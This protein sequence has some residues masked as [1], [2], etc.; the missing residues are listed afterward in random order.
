MTDKSL[1]TRIAPNDEKALLMRRLEIPA[2]ANCGGSPMCS[3]RSEAG[4][5]PK[6][7]LKMK[8][9]PGMCMKTKDRMT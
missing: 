4:R 5:S 6:E 3:A 7:I 9:P 1:A 8:E 2:C